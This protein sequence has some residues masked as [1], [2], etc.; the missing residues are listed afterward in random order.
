M[1]LLPASG[2]QCQNIFS[3]ISEPWVCAIAETALANGLI[4]KQTNEQG[5]TLF[6]GTN[7]LSIYE[8]LALN[9]KSQCIR[10]NDSSIP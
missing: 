8:I 6:R 2:Y 5:E 3:D 1:K 7:P 4:S 9:L 10:V